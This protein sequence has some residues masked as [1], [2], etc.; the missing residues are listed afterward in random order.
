MTIDVSNVIR[1]RA[2]KYTMF[3]PQPP[4][5]VDGY[6]V[7]GTEFR[8]VITATVQ[9]VAGDELRNLPPGQN[10]ENWRSVWSVDEVNLRDVIV[11]DGTRFTVEHVQARTVDGQYWKAMAARAADTLN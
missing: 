1:R 11:I 2:Q 5:V 9:P 10:S 8:S 7:P 4:T 3:S 6:A